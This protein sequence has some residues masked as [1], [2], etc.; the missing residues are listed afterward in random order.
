MFPVHDYLLSAPS[1]LSFDGAATDTLKHMEAVS[2]LSDIEDAI[3]RL[4]Q[5]LRNIEDRQAVETD[6]PTDV[7]T[8]DPLADALRMQR[9]SINTNSSKPFVITR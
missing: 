5:Q 4:R 3:E 6:V 7:A 9:R 1:R 2:K 8:G